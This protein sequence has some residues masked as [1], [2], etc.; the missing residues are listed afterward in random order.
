MWNERFDADADSIRMRRFSARTP[1]RLESGDWLS[2]WT[3]LWIWEEQEAAE[4]DLFFVVVLCIGRCLLVSE[5]LEPNTLSSSQ[6]QDRA[7]RQH[8]QHNAA[9]HSELSG[10]RWGTT[11][12]YVLDLLPSSHFV[13]SKA[14][15]SL[16]RLNFCSFS[17][18]W[19]DLLALTRWFVI[20][21]SQVVERKVTGYFQ[22]YADLKKVKQVDSLTKVLINVEIT[23]QK[24]NSLK[25][26]LEQGVCFFFY[27]GIFWFPGEKTDEWSRLE[28]FFFN[29]QRNISVNELFNTALTSETFMRRFT[30]CSWFRQEEDVVRS[31]WRRSGRWSNKLRV[32]G[33]WS[34]QCLG[35]NRCLF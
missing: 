22:A 17:C 13:T 21:E 20:T 23:A 12:R 34:I 29:N 28:T 5:R 19:T 7:A 30:K 4:D 16:C 35:Q 8:L 10:P 27:Q 32:S 9:N 31:P 15:V 18:W 6:L 2:A 26:E 24:L 14:N 11:E 3:L 25:S 1:C 33:K